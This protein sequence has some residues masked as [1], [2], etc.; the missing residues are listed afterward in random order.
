MALAVRVMVVEER[1]KGMNDGRVG[2]GD[3]RN[4]KPGKSGNRHLLDDPNWNSF[5]LWRCWEAFGG[6][7]KGETTES[8]RKIG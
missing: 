3:E 7:V 6:V 2:K 1:V 4:Q 8:G 5:S